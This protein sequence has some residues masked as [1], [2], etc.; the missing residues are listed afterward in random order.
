MIKVMLANYIKHNVC[1]NVS[2]LGIYYS[3]T[4]GTN[5]YESQ[6]HEICQWPVIISVIIWLI[7]FKQFLTRIFVVSVFVRK[8]F[9]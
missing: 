6:L 3:Y 2:S 9:I 1:M 8:S 5:T 4:E 7:Y